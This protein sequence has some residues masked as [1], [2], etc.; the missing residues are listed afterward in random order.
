[1][2]MHEKLNKDISEAEGRRSLNCGANWPLNR[3]G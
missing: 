3:G 1:M 2:N